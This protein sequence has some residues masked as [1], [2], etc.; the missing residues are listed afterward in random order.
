MLGKVSGYGE[1][2]GWRFG[3]RGWC[4]AV[5]EPRAMPDR[6]IC[7]SKGADCL[8]ESSTNSTEF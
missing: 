8:G 1:V 7:R 2:L 3:V 5:L 6:R 4:V